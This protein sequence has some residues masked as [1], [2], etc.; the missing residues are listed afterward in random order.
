[1]KLAHVVG[2]FNK[3]DYLREDRA[4]DSSECSQQM[5]IELIPSDA[6]ENESQHR[7]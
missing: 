2:A 1:M 4:L 6:K 7:E 3:L 5:L